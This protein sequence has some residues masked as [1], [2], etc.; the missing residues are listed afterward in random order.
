MRNAED[1]VGCWIFVKIQNKN[2]VKMLFQVIQGRVKELISTS[3]DSR[4]QLKS[5]RSLFGRDVKAILKTDS[6][7]RLNA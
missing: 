6:I 5:V 4:S 7:P 1:L 3:G 2:Q